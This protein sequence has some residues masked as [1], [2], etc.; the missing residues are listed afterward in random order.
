MM[1]AWVGSIP[2]VIGSSSAIAMAVPR[3]GSM[4]TAVPM[5]TPIEG[6][7]Q[8]AGGQDRGEAVEQ[9]VEVLH[10]SAFLED[11]LENAGGQAEAQ[12]DRESVER[13]QGRVRPPPRA[14]MK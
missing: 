7:E 12:P 6:D 4:P 2:Y 1:N 11:S 10:G 13:G 5:V 14:Q 9:G 8:V 3:P